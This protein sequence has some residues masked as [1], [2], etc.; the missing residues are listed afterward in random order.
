MQIKKLLYTFVYGVVAMFF[1][2]VINKLFDWK[3]SFFDSYVFC[4]TVFWHESLTSA[5]Q[6]SEPRA[7]P[8]K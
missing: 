5:K 2:I 7:R 4:W 1:C 8:E 6:A 3:V